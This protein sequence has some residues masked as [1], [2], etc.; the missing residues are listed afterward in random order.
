LYHP[1][2]PDHLPAAG[3]KK[4]REIAEDIPVFLVRL[5]LGWPE[6][7][8]RKVA[9]EELTPDRLEAAHNAYATAFRTRGQ[10]HLV[11]V[12]REALREPPPELPRPPRRGRPQE[13]FSTP[14]PKV[15]KRK[16]G[17]R[18]RARRS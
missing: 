12:S 13:E 11:V 7:V 4:L 10:V 6:R 5:R 14:A 17:K 15:R 2:D 18:A 9:G 1:G 16:R 8:L 3:L